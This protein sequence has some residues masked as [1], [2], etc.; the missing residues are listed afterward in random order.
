M[1]EREGAWYCDICGGRIENAESMWRCP[2]NTDALCNEC[3]GNILEQTKPDLQKKAPP[4]RQKQVVWAA[5]VIIFFGLLIASKIGVFVNWLLGLP[6]REWVGPTLI[7][8]GGLVVWVV[9]AIL[10]EIVVMRKAARTGS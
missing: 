6:Q 7:I 5:G 2:A 4:S 8:F 3:V 9:G 1:G 10:I